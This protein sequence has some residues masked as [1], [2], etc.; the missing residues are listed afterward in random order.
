M[1]IVCALSYSKVPHGLFIGFPWRSRVPKSK[2]GNNMKFVHVGNYRQRQGFDTRYFLHIASAMRVLTFCNTGSD[3]RT[4][5]RCSF[6]FSTLVSFLD[7]CL[8]CRCRLVSQ[9]CLPTP[10]VCLHTSKVTKN[11]RCLGSIWAY[12]GVI[13]EYHAN[14]P[15]LDSKK[16]SP[17]NK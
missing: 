6:L 12:A 10:P 14:H 7:R 4:F 8:H 17:G 3:R 15:N 11:H 2:C 13:Y 5:C 9:F 16:N 1:R